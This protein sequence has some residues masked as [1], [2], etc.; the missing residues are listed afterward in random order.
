MQPSAGA[1]RQVLPP[2]GQ[3]GIAEAPC[4]HGASPLS[5]RG[6]LRLSSCC[7]VPGEHSAAQHGLVQDCA[8]LTG[9][10]HAWQQ[11]FQAPQSA[12]L[13]TRDKIVGSAPRSQTYELL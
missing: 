1:E 9:L 10:K 6:E 13:T 5:S 2:I 4:C 7:A 12:V 3:A 11:M 8:L